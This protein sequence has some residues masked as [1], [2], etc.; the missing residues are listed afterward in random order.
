MP[1]YVAH[2]SSAGVLNA[3]NGQGRL[4]AFYVVELAARN[5]APY[6]LGC[7]SKK[8][9]FPHASDLLFFEMMQFTRENGKNTINLGL[10]V[11]EGIRRFKEKWG[12]VPYLPYEFCERYYGYTRTISLIKS[13]EGKL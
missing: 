2:S 9:Y 12:G 10:G 8:Y 7:H 3:R 5:F 6:V 13:F 11:N 4:C 1:D